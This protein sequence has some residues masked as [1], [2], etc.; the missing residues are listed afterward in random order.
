MTRI[1]K[2]YQERK[3]ELLEAA[4]ELFFSKGY[5]QTSVESIIEK[6]G[7]SK[8]TFYYY[9]KSKVELL[10]NLTERLSKQ[11]LQEVKK[12]VERTDLDAL[13]KLNRVYAATRNTKF[14]NIEL[15]RILLKVLYDDKNLFFRYK[16]YRSNIE[17]LAPEFIKII[18]QGIKEKLFNTPFPEEAA[19]LIF[20]LGF[21]L[22][23]RITKL[24]LE[25]DKN[26]ENLDR[27][28]KEFKAYENAMER[29]IGAE[30]GTVHIVERKI[31]KLFYKKI[32]T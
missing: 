14:E 15:L 4:Q 20:E 30:K 5:E 3:N 13:T 12:I 21:V 23:E 19:K 26:P 17:L 10:D 2:E 29:I 18:K 25:I 11:I 27:V 22:G 1:I 32:N 8:G 28:E 31:L 7:V 9:F 16:I 24:I 6:V